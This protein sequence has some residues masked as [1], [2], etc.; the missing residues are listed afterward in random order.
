MTDGTRR[1]TDGASSGSRRGRRAFLSRLTA[2]TGAVGA[3]GALAGCGGSDTS[4]TSDA[5]EPS[6]PPDPEEPAIPPDLQGPDG[7]FD[8]VPA[9]FDSIADL[10]EFGADPSAAGSLEAAV[11][12]AAA[13]G[14]LLFLPSGRYRMEGVLELSGVARFGLVGG[15]ATRVPSSGTTETDDGSVLLDSLHFDL[16]GN[17]VE[18]RAVDARVSDRLELFDVSVTGTLDA[19]RGAVRVDVTDPDGSGVVERLSLRDGAAAETTATGCYVGDENRGSITF[20]DCEIEG[21][22][23][24]GLYAAP[25]RGR[26]VVEGGY[27]AN[28]GI[29]NVRVRSGSVVR[30]VHVRCDAGDRPL[31]NMRGIR[32]SNDAPTADAEPTV[33][34]D[35]VVE[36]V[37]VT[38]SDGAITLSEEVAAA[39]IRDATV[40]V[41]A[42]DVRALWA[43]TPHQS[44][45]SAEAA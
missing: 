38:G 27:Y 21:F 11:T 3:L 35:V 14:R 15:E 43:K 8:S 42:D 5:E 1:S 32:L 18:S 4:D 2:A 26:I 17:G 33:V 22:P 39:E 13:D 7:P 10:A 44:I 45:Q 9:P 37:D 31:K 34:E 41:H 23:D 12:D 40:V 19:G 20:R 30:G 28:N 6:T 25:S 36:M 29:A 24:N 16:G